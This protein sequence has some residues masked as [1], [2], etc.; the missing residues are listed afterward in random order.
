VPDGKDENDNIVK[1]HYGEKTNIINPKEHFEL[2]NN[3]DI[4]AGVKLS[5]SRFNVLHGEIAKLERCLGQ[6]MLDVQIDNGFIETSVPLLVNETALFGTGQ[7]PKFE[8]DLFKTTD[9]RYLIPTAEVPLT[10]L[11]ANTIIQSTE[12]S[13]CIRLTALTPCF[14]SEVGSAGKDVRGILRQHQF[15]KVEMV[16][17]CEPEYSNIEHEY[18][19]ECAEMVLDMLELPYR[20][21]LL[22]SGDTGFSSAKTYDLEVWL[23]GQN[24]YREISSISNMKDFQARRMNTKYRTV[25]GEKRFVH[26]LNGSGVAVGRALIA[27][28]ENHQLPN[29]KIKIPLDLQSYMK[30][31]TIG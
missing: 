26:T 16:S 7:L 24:C 30:C 19:T 21:V 4:Q 17:I 22:C 31:E 14:R 6:F 25:N 9:G 23:P 12:L 15:Y 18:M 8:D 13:P 29:G 11:V 5:G 10:N 1:I 28:L 3:I 20:K 2:T 27:I